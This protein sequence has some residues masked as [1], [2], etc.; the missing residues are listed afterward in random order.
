MKSRWVYDCAICFDRIGARSHTRPEEYRGGGGVLGLSPS[1]MLSCKHRSPA[2][3][4]CKAISLLQLHNGF[5]ISHTSFGCLLPKCSF[6]F[7]RESISCMHLGHLYCVEQGFMSIQRPVIEQP[8]AP[9][10]LCLL[11]TLKPPSCSQLPSPSPSAA[12]G[13]SAILLPSFERRLDGAPRRCE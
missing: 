5:Q 8:D 12:T 7:D 13:L 2:Q 6:I 11:S 4:A 1:V 3:A 9:S 10:G